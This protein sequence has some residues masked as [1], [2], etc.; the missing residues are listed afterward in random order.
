MVNS[1]HKTSVIPERIK[2]DL[3]QLAKD[4]KVPEQPLALIEAFALLLFP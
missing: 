3:L 4:T 2:P 1:G